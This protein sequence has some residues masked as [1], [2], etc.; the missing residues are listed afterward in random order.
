[1]EKLQ[2]LLK[3]RSDIEK[4][5][6][7]MDSTFSD[8]VPT[9]AEEFSVAAVVTDCRTDETVI[10]AIGEELLVDGRMYYI[11]VVAADKW[12]NE[13]R[14]N[15]QIVNATP[16]KTPGME[17]TKPDRVTLLDAWDVADDLFCIFF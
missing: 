4:I 15:V 8:A 2:R 3:A 16:F 9:T 6:N 13:D 10:S 1:M 7:L 12:L 17:A 14:T 11:T 5:S